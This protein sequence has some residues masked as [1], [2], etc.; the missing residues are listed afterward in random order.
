MY[1]PCS[2]KESDKRPLRIGRYTYCLKSTV[3]IMINDLGI[4]RKK[5]KNHVE[6]GERFSIL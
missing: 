4:G 2:R 5:M 3:S 6:H 1:L